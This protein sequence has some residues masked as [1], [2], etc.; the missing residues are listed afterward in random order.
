MTDTTQSTGQVIASTAVQT[1]QALLPTILT[2]AATGMTQPQIALLAL[3]PTFVQAA[4]TLK[5]AGTATPEQLA[6]IWSAMSAGVQSDHE[7]LQAELAKRGIPAFL[8]NQAA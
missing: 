2:S 3:L 8:A 1:L 7:R 6:A 5:N 4:E